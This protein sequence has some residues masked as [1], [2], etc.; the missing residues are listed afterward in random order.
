MEYFFDES[1]N[2]G[3]A[4]L[5]NW[6]KQPT[7]VLAAVGKEK[8]DNHLMTRVEELRKKHHIQMPELKGSKLY[9]SKSRFIRDVVQFL[10]EED[11]PVF[12]EVVD[13]KYH[14]TMM[15]TT[16]FLSSPVESL[17]NVSEVRDS[18]I[19]A[20][21]I[22][23]DFD[24]CVLEAYAEA[25]KNRSAEA[26]YEFLKV[27]ALET[28][29]QYESVVDLSDW[30]DS[31]DLARW[32]NLSDIVLRGQAHTEHFQE[33]A[34]GGE[35]EDE[36]VGRFLPPPDENKSGGILALLPHV[37]C[38][39]NLYLR[40]NATVDNSE[41]RLVHDLQDQFD[42]LL[43]DYQQVLSSNTFAIMNK[44]SEEAEVPWRDRTNWQFSDNHT[45]DFGDS[46]EIIG[47]QLADLIAGFCRKYYEESIKKNGE[48]LA[49]THETTAKLLWGLGESKVG[50]GVNL[51]TTFERA[52]LT[53]AKRPA[54]Y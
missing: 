5:L 37:T 45:I 22:F 7:F 1:G 2:T 53:F 3:D 43:Q 12:V 29:K 52:R 50:Q 10:I 40:L 8:E 48:L 17:Q 27:F 41:V 46:K 9:N 32:A 13:K 28:R 44:L 19:I 16:Y 30:S 42:L 26:T 31:M 25:C 20:E 18:N 35:P 51:V 34:K 14:L 11:Y 47:I 6:V 21:I 49:A 33:L 54:D 24:D 15:L 36:L 39:A 23:N 4:A 38:F